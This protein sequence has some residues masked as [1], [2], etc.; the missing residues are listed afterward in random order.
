MRYQTP[1]KRSA[2]SADGL[3]DGP[4]TPPPVGA[5]NAR[6][7]Q[8][9]RL[10]E[11]V[12]APKST[13]NAHEDNKKMLQWRALQELIHIAWEHPDQVQDM[14]DQCKLIVEGSA[15]DQSEKWDSSY[16]RVGKLPSYWA[17][18]MLMRMT[19]LAKDDLAT[20]E[21]SEGGI[22]RKIFNKILELDDGDTLPVEMLDKVVCAAVVM[23][24]H[25]V[26]GSQGTSF[27]KLYL[28]QDGTLDVKKL[29]PY[30]FSFDNNGDLVGVTHK[31]TN[32][33]KNLKDRD[34]AVVYTKRWKLAQPLSAM[35][36][37]FARDGMKKPVHEFFDEGTGPHVNKVPSAKGKAA[38]ERNP[39]LAIARQLQGQIHETRSKTRAAVVKAQ[40]VSK[41]VV[42][43]RKRERLDEAVKKLQDSGSAGSKKAKVMT[44]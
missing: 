35:H 33:H 6:I 9:C 20:L 14:R 17:E 26:C 15:Q 2:S 30:D 27:K 36:A 1:V 10:A 40:A 37:H 5:G 25:E 21:T 4:E 22:C 42:N 44:F 38:R 39:L 3:A 7:L 12:T 29:C 43:R 8:L 13:G 28:N 24:R 11:S 31:Q 18:M 32:M 23:Q 16:H 19:A 41:E 34:A